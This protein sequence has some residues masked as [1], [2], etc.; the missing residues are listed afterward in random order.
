MAGPNTIQRVPRGATGIF[1]LKSGGIL[2]AELAPMIQGTSD[3]TQLYLQDAKR[4]FS[5]G[6]GAPAAGYVTTGCIVPAGEMWIP[7]NLTLT[8]TTGAAGI[9]VLY[10]VY[11][12]NATINTVRFLGDAITTAASLTY[13]FG[14]SFQPGE[15][16]AA[17]GTEFAMY[18]R[19]AAGAFTSGTCYLDYYRVLL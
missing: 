16:F 7:I 6:F 14:H 15:L 8:I 2:P 9:F 17:P 12:N 18:C 5:G 11:A 19:S 3:V 13:Y 4:T 1:D 10:P